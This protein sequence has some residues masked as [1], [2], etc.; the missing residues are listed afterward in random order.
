M[1]TG[2]R[3]TDDMF[4]DGLSLYKFVEKSFPQNI[5]DI[6]DPRIVPSYEDDEEE[7][8][9]ESVLNQENHP[10]VG[11]MS[12]IIELVKLGLLCAAETPKDRPEMQDVY[13]NVTAIR[14]V[15]SA[16]QG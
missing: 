1:L 16:L 10:M 12:C 6:L 2:K 15:F 8:E 13:S 4:N 14:E 9:A 11:T 5:D 3:P 7:E